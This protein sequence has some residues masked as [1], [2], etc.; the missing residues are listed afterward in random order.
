MQRQQRERERREAQH[1][2]IA[3]A[4]SGGDGCCEVFIIGI[5]ATGLF[6]LGMIAIWNL[7]PVLAG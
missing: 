1:D 7:A 2:W 4:L 3:N 6:L 5:M